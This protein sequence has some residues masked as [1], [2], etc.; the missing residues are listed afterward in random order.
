[1]EA[2]TI[3]TDTSERRQDA[4]FL[5]DDNFE[6]KILFT[7][8]NPR[9]LG[10]TFACSAV[11]VSKSGLQINS[12]HPL[13]IKSVLD[14]SITVKDSNRN[15]LVTGDVKWCKPTT[16]FAHAIGIQLKTRSGTTTDLDDWKTLIKHIK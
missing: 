5:V 1:M 8:D 7:S 6:I 4:R 15:Y 14:L 13:A 3:A 12:E 9:V 16:G 10:K 11:D 2:A